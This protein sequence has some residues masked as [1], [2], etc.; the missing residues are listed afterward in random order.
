MSYYEPPPPLDMALLIKPLN[1][2]VNSFLK[3]V[4]P[5]HNTNQSYSYWRSVSD[6]DHFSHTDTVASK[7]HCPCVTLKQSAFTCIELSQLIEWENES[8]SIK[9][10]TGTEMAFLYW[11]ATDISRFITDNQRGKLVFRFSDLSGS[12]RQ[13]ERDSSMKSDLL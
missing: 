12:R 10:L 2:N 5:W 13:S 11:I 9:I 3:V 8:T 7:L 4:F 6:Y 1:S